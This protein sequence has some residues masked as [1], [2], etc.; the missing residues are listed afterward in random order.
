M[1]FMYGQVQTNLL[2]AAAVLVSRGED[3]NKAGTVS[4]TQMGEAGLFDESIQP[5]EGL[6]LRKVSP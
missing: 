5:W 1:S 4:I 6:R 2:T 3:Q